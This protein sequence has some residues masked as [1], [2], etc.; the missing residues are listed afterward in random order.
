M[1]ER[2]T[3]FSFLVVCFQKSGA[4]S[5]ISLSKHENHVEFR[6]E[7]ENTNLERGD[8]NDWLVLQLICD[9]SLTLF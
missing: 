1:V 4:V 2:A 9:F 3:Y 5:Q 7:A 8:Q 6:C